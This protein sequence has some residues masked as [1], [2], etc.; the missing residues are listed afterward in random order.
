[1]FLSPALIGITASASASGS[2]VITNLNIYANN[3]LLAST[4]TNVLSMIWEN[5]A[6][7][8]YLL[9]ASAIDSANRTKVSTPISVQILPNSQNRA[10]TAVTDTFV[11]N[12]NSFNNDF[13]VLG[14]DSDP[15]GDALQVISVTAPGNGG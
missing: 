13:P 1:S 9:T 10:P 15:D 4:T 8:A 14:N 11:V 3:I 5:A 2:D 12:A 6:P 7:G